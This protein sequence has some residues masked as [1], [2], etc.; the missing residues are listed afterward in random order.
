MVAN[1][2]ISTN[3]RDRLSIR[4]RLWTLFILESLSVSEWWSA[5]QPRAFW[6]Y[7]WGLRKTLAYLFNMFVSDESGIQVTWGEDCSYILES[8][9]RAKINRISGQFQKS[10]VFFSWG[11][12]WTLLGQTKTIQCPW[13]REGHA[14]DLTYFVFRNY[15]IVFSSAKIATTVS[16]QNEKK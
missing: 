14:G 4:A 5:C 7:P 16:F 1:V 8:N 13:P 9:P 11:S 12:S 10:L 2:S 3:L 15:F 6:D